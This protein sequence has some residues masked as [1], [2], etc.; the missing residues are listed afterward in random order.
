MTTYRWQYISDINLY[1]Y[2]VQ[3]YSMVSKGIPRDD[4]KSFLH[5]VETYGSRFQ[6]RG[7][8]VQ[9]LN[10]FR[11]TRNEAIKAKCYDCMGFYDQANDKNCRNYTCPLY[12][13]MPYK[14]SKP[15]KQSEPEE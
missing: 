14:N 13:Y 5:M 15:S 11:I 10:G 8:L 9:F 6:G 2:Q 3:H 12:P 7:E 1:D 4:K